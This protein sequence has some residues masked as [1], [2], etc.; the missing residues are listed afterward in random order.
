MKKLFINNRI[1]Y[2]IFLSFAIIFTFTYI[3]Q[4][5]LYSDCLFKEEEINIESTI[6]FNLIDR[7]NESNKKTIHLVT[8]IFNKM[9]DSKRLQLILKI[10]NDHQKIDSELINLTEQNLIII[11]KLAYNLNVKP[12]S[13]KG[14]NSD[15]YLL[16]L[17]VNQIKNQI[18]V[19]DKIEKTSHNT[20][21]KIFAIK[22]KNILQRNSDDLQIRSSN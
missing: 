10:E 1:P 19:F 18:I 14:K 21:F 15:F 4:Q 22:S 17:L 9:S 2:K 13:L 16:S 5:K 11:P 12:N 3:T 8:I 7:L 6:D 20:A